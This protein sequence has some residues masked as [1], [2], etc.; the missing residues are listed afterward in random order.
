MKFYSLIICL[1][2]FTQI[3]AQNLERYISK[4]AQAVVEIDGSQIFS[5]IDMA[6][7][8]MMMP[9]DPSGEPMNI[10]QYGFNVKSKAYYFMNIK[11]SINYQN[12]II[13]LSDETKAEEF[14]SSM[15]PSEPL[16]VN[17]F[18]FASQGNMT[19]AWNSN[20][21]ILT[22]AEFPKK[23]YTL[24][25]LVAEKEEEAR[26][27]QEASEDYTEDSEE[28][29]VEENEEVYETED[30]DYESD[31]TYEDDDYTDIENLEFEL[32]MKNMD[33]PSMYTDE[34]INSMM[35]DNFTSILNTT[36]TQSIASDANYSSGKKA[37]ASA[38]FW[39][40]NLD[41]LMSDAM[42]SELTSLVG[43]SNKPLPT[44]ME[45][46]TGNLTFTE[47]EIRVESS[48]AIT[49]SIAESYSKMYTNIDKSFLNHFDHEDALAYMSLSMDMGKMLEEY[50]SI[51][52]NLYGSYFSEFSDE[53][54][55]VMDLIEVVIDEE[56]IGELIT[57]DGLMVLHNIENKE[58]TYTTTEY[59]DD[60]NAT[61]VE[62]T[63]MEPL[64]IF[65]LMMGS[66]NKSMFSRLMRIAKKYD[67]IK[68][69]GNRYHIPT[70][71]MGLPFDMYLVQND[72]IVY[73]TNS[74]QKIGD[75]ASG[76][77]TKNLGKHKKLLKNNSYNLYINSTDL[78]EN[79]SDMIPIDPSTMDSVRNYYK[80]IYLTSEK[81]KD[82]KMNVDFVVKTSGDK[83]NSLK[84]IL[85]S[86]NTTLMSL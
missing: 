68:I 52:K 21:A 36:S 38:Y 62:K 35:T 67:A 33:A 40:K 75:Y 51:V 10:E 28:E 74:T 42:P 41:G 20:I 59:D 57:G 76:K 65:S 60:F 12:L 32:L 53:I 29:Y 26:L 8:E 80:E 82:N 13:A 11:E 46:I 55:V 1:F 79:L 54:G 48:F 24:N 3:Q 78:M 14:I 58:V 85:D 7:I 43:G 17:G 50:P 49:P 81:M 37:N 61:E 30:E 19:A 72:G 15:L 77:K 23:V 83:G 27:A 18:K 45:A 71:D 73:L 25:D 84:L 31:Y 69:D 39:I 4:D 66:E 16:M 86:M 63:K 64:P 47:D 9:P 70:Q 2:I 5:L 44:G 22:S 34:E 6:D 56:A